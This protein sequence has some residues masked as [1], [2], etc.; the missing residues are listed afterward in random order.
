MESSQIVDIWNTFKDSLDKKHTEIVAEK[1]VEVCADYGT[2]DTEFRDA[3]GSCDILDA[4][5]GYYLDIDDDGED[6]DDEWDD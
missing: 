5:I 1:F 6:I 2:D 3:M 4:A